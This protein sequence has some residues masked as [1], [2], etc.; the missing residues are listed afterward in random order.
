MVWCGVVQGGAVCV[1][2]CVAS[3]GTR[4]DLHS[5]VGQTVG[6]AAA[7]PLALEA[8]V[9]HAAIVTLLLQQPAQEHKGLRLTNTLSHQ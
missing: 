5:P 8:Q 6:Q 2:R 7:Q 4:S 9:L 3:S 1:L